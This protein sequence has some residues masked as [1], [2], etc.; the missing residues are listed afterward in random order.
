VEEEG[1]PTGGPV[2]AETPEAAV[3]PVAD[4]EP[5]LPEPPA[6]SGPPEV[7]DEPAPPRG[8][9][10]EGPAVRVHPDRLERGVGPIELSPT[11]ALRL[12]REGRASLVRRELPP[13]QGP[14]GSD[15]DGP[16]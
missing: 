1:G 13:D 15:A 14:E 6:A 4:E 3:A 8:T 9:A 16:S 2:A 5:S 11:E 7:A 12:A 10:G